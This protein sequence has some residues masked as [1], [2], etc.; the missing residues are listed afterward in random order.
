MAYIYNGVFL[1]HKKEGNDIICSN[2]D[3][4]R[5]Y[6]TKWNKPDREIQISYDI[7]YMWD[8]KKWYKWTYLQSRNRLIDIKNKLILTKGEG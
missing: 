2:I 7:T 8:P 3:E 6:H 1:S 5:D 4:P